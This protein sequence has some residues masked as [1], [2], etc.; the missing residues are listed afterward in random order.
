MKI[1]GIEGM[2]QMS[3]Q[4][5]INRG[6]KFVIYTYCIS[7]ILISF[8]RSS[9]IYFIKYREGAVKK[10]LQ[11]TL[12][13]ALLGWWGIPWGPIYTVGALITNLGGGKDVTEEVMNSLFEN[14]A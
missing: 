2:A 9:N 4:D 8:K 10:G 11:F 3:I 1:I 5:E 6:G 7:I 12:L 13:S 14:V